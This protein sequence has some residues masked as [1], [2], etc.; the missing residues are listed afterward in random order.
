MIVT[1]KYLFKN[2]GVS[3]K[4][5]SREIISRPNVA[6]STKAKVFVLISFLGFRNNKITQSFE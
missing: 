4:T 1:I 5:V 2:T 6:D 3:I